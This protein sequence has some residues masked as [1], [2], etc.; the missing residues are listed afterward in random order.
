MIL[1]FERV[2]SAGI[3]TN[4]MSFKDLGVVPQRYWSLIG[5]GYSLSS[6]SY[7]SM[8]HRWCEGARVSR[9]LPGE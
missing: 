8:F 6:S 9:S 2:S 5:R 4:F 7:G 3:I 1:A